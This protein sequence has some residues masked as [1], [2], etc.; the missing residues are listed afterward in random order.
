TAWP[1][2]ARMVPSACAASSHFFFCAKYASRAL[3]FHELSIGWSSCSRFS[4][5]PTRL[6]YTPV[7]PS[8]PCCS[9]SKLTSMVPTEVSLHVFVPPRCGRGPES[10]VGPGELVDSE[11]VGD[12]VELRGVLLLLRLV[13]PRRLDERLVHRVQRVVEL[14]A[15][16]GERLVCVAERRGR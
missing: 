10:F 9:P 15:L 13:R 1:I 2:C 6:R 12:R 3:P 16:L 14:P 8:P 11:L 7:M 4:S 5:V